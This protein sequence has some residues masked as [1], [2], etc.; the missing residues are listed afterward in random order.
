MDNFGTVLRIV[1]EFA[2]DSNIEFGGAVLRPHAY[3]MAENKEKAEKIFEA[4]RQE[5]YE[6]VKERKMSKGLLK[7]I[8]QPLI[9][10]KNALSV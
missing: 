6:L 7:L 1:E 5:D 8:G 9:S 3:L 2:K 4:A 10:E